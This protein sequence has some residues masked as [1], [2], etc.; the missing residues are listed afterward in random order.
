[1][2]AAETSLL[3]RIPAL[4]HPALPSEG[5]LAPIGAVLANY[6]WTWIPECRQAVRAIDPEAVDRGESP[7][8][9]LMDPTRAERLTQNREFLRLSAEAESALRRYLTE[10][11]AVPT[12]F[13]ERSPVAYF[14]AEFG[15][16]ESFPQ[17]CGG[18]GILAGDH[19]REASD[20]GLPLVGVGLFYRL[21]FFLQA[22]EPDGRQQ[23][24]YPGLDPLEHPLRRVL[25]PGTGQPLT[26]RLRFP[27]REVSA[28]VWLVAV[29][30]TPLL[31]LDT[32]LPEN[33]L[34]DRAVTWRKYRFFER[35]YQALSLGICGVKALATLEIE[36][37]V[38]HMNGQHSALLLV[39][40]MSKRLVDGAAWRKASEEVRQRAIL[41][42]HTLPRDSD[43][44][45]VE[46]VIE[47]LKPTI[48][49]T[50]ANPWRYQV[51]GKGMFSHRSVFDMT[52]FA[53]RLSKAANGVSLLHGRTAD[54]TWRPVTGK[55]V[56]AVTSGVHLPTWLGPEM[57][58][59]YE[60]NG[61]RVGQ[62]EKPRL[63]VR[64][65]RRPL[66]E[67][68]E[69]L[70]GRALWDAHQAQK[71]R[72][73]AFA[74]DRLLR[75]HVRFGRS[76]DELERAESVL[77]PDAFLVG[78]VRRPVSYERPSLFGAN[79]SYVGMLVRNSERPM[80]VLF[81]VEELPLGSDGGLMLTRLCRLT[82][83]RHWRGRVFC[84]EEYDIAV[85]RHLV[86][87]VDLWIS[88]P[89]RPLEASGT[90]GM[91]AAI[92]GVPNASVLD[93]WWDE[94]FEGDNGWA[95]GEREAPNNP[96]KRDRHH[97]EAL[98]RALEE[99]SALFWDRTD[100][101]VPEGWVRMMKRAI[102]SSAWAFS[103][104]RM[105]E[106]YAEGMYL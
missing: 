79:P 38:F 32:D 93:G 24:L 14:C 3:A 86:Q 68:L 96:R 34:R 31:L 44:F 4:P 101:G 78:F 83:S 80:Q 102:A 62:A 6:A 56:G 95:V 19:L 40:L 63:A 98:Y 42:V 27:R 103:T 74:N 41:T 100:D 64:E 65:G 104:R 89:I 9:L 21:G 91:K 22:L 26:V 7:I 50:G 81:A 92:N 23:H 55:P 85:A 87:G 5:P 106:D 54:G 49:G 28:A 36:P 94:G 59:L 25:D 10:C 84:L 67:G 53:L 12:S 37:I 77:N 17:Y 1:M 48:E 13:D 16:H 35:F 75:Q 30:R 51:L 105:L 70:D 2:S 76:P 45:E 73:V 39:E 69:S 61:Y 88:D 33:R 66:W 72:L 11:P 99:A 29:G 71:R 82:R 47:L 15:L 52:A 43:R 60:R 90:S 57:R 8:R 46:R 18:L 58:A 20:M 97:A